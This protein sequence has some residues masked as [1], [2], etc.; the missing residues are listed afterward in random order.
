VQ[1]VVADPA[2]LCGDVPGAVGGCQVI[3][4]SALRHSFR[5]LRGNIG[6][7]AV[8][9]ALGNF[10][11][12]MVF[13]YASLYVL[14]LGGDAAIIGLIN[15]FRPLM[16]LIMFP[17]GGYFADHASS[18]VKLI[19]LSNIFATG[20]VLMRFVAPSWELLAVAAV[21]QGLIAVGFPS[22]S[23]LIAD[24]LAP[25]DRGRGIATMN[26]VAS[27]LAI[28]AP[29]IAGL[30]VDAY[31]PDTGVRALYGAMLVLYLV[32]PL[33][34]IRFLSEVPRQSSRRF[35]LSDVPRVLRDTY[36]GTPALVR[37]LS[38]TTK[39][40]AVVIVLNFMAN[41][42]ASSFWVVYAV[43]EIGLSSS[44]WG[45]ILLVETVLR[46]LLFLPAG[47]LVDRW[48]RTASLLTAL[49]LA[50][51]SIPA[52]VLVDGFW[53]V[54]LIRLLVA[55]AL[56]MAVLGSTA[57]MADTVPRQMRGRVMAALGHGGFMI[58]A[59]GG[60]T[61]GPGVG[62]LVTIPLMLASFAGGLLYAANPVYPW[63]FVGGAMALS[64]VVTALFIRDP[65][66]AEE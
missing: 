61:G 53:P 59:V 8:S 40:L 43:E 35:R 57:L 41:G 26:M 9:L 17:L 25:A 42:V 32:T 5:F 66:R 15:A 33:I 64:I 63:L 3:R 14:A 18:R 7:F 39:A 60:G 30:V 16:G 31:G 19:V 2:G 58:G 20:I 13:P 51:F 48:G 28:M 27:S 24:S 49:T 12:Q 36:S 56:A 55:V 38:R 54:L 22:R 65:Q 21:F 1:R 62:Y 4:L 6:V 37:G 45:L 47:I 46:M 52:F 50:L 11:R 10:A 34:Q 23:A 29:F 44:E